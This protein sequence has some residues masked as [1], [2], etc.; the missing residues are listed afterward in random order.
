MRELLTA[1]LEIL[2]DSLEVRDEQMNWCAALSGSSTRSLLPALESMSQ[3]GLEAGLP[4][5]D[6]R[7]V[8]AR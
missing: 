1:P 2:G 8:V 3:A 5:R 4:A 7:R 6:A